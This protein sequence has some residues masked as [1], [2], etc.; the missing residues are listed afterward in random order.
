MSQKLLLDSNAVIWTIYS[1][2]DLSTKA[3][4]AVE[5]NAVELLVSHASLWELLGKIGR[6]KL[7][8]A[9][10][11]VDRAMQRI[12]DLGV[13]FLPVEEHHILA[14]AN[15]PQHHSD[16]FDRVIIAQAL[17]RKVSVVTSDTMFHN[18]GIQV[19]WK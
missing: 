10:T 2:S 1:P 15:L 12:R 9:G 19:L 16:P 18:Y 7:L 4:A 11:S 14:A 8:L 13:T 5:D 17:D 6:G 3:K